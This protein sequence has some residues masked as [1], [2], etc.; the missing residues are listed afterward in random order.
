[1]ATN[2]V[3][4]NEVIEEVKEALEW[5]EQNRIKPD[6]YIEKAKKTYLKNGGEA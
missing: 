6:E 3:N 2:G 1:M 4:W 5:F